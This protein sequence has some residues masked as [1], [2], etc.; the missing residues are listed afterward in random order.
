MR[1]VYTVDIVRNGWTLQSDSLPHVLQPEV[2]VSKSFRWFTT[3]YHYKAR[4]PQ[5]DSLPVPI[6]DYLTP[7]EQ[8]L[9]F[10]PNELPADWTGTDLYNMLD[11]LNTKYVKWW[12]HCLFE[13]EMEAYAALCDSTQRALLAHYHDTLLALILNDLPNERKSFGNVAQNFPELD[14]IGE[15]DRNDN[16]LS[17]TATFWAYEHWNLDAQ[18]LWRVVLPGDRMVEHMVS[19]DRMITPQIL[20]Q[21]IPQDQET[22]QLATIHKEGDHSF[23]NEREIL[24]KILF[25]LRSNVNE[26]RHEMSTLKKQIEDVQGSTPVTPVTP[27]PSTQLAPAG[28]K[29]Q[30]PAFNGQEATFNVQRSTFNV[31]E[32]AEAEEYVEPEPENLNVNDWSRQALEKALNRNGGNRK[33]AAQELGISDRTLYRRLKQ[34]GLDK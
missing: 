33:R 20:S 34:Y 22:T 8:R 17:F 2:T 27:L 10:T 32:D 16:A 30:Q 3:R 7:D 24:Y 25:E 23:E 31:S 5:L 14:F 29:V 1:Y 11:K 6:S 9:L 13:K 21:F 12:N 28:Y 18:V 15:L 4:F 26:M 19:A